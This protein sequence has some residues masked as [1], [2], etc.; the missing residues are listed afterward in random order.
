MIYKEFEIKEDG[1]LDYAKL[2]VYIQDDSD[3]MAIEKRPLILICP[4]GGYAYTS[5]REAEPIAL[6]FMAAGFNTA[7]LR[8]SCA[9][10]RYPVALT[11]VSR[12][13]KII[14][15]NAKE[16]HVDTD[17]VLIMGFSAGGHLAANYCCEWHNEDFAG[18]IVTDN[19]D[20]LK[21]NGLILGYPVITSGK[22]AHRGSF[23]NLLGEKEAELSNK[24]S[25]EK[26]VNEY[27]PSTFIWATY[28]DGSVPVENSLLFTMALKEKGINTELH[29]FPI[30]GHGLALANELTLSNNK[31]E[32]VP[33]CQIWTDL[34]I[35]W[36]KNL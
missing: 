16:W 17:K 15:D 18:R 5:D 3:S 20:I 10:A 29:I 22:F 14:R 25:L 30:G 19:T 9:P 27:V 1:S 35:T 2:T 28:T 33:Q 26:Q 8:Y 4:G 7:I 32:C 36:A 34:A 12:S 31:T 23:E 11:E 24:V 13:F 6:V 21:P